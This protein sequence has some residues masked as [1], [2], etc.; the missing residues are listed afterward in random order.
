MNRTFLT[1]ITALIFLIFISVSSFAGPAYTT[2]QAKILKP[3]G[4]PL[5]ANPVQF[6]FTILNSNADCILYAETFSNINMNSSNGLISF[7][8]GSG[9]KNYPASATTFE[10]VFSN[11]TPTLSCNGVSP[12]TYSPASADARKVVMQFHDGSGWQTLPAMSINAVPY[13]MYANEAQKISGMPT[14]T[15]GEA[16]FY[17]GTTFS[18]VAASG[19]G[20]V[21]SG[22]VITALG[23]TPADGVSVTTLSSSITSANANI[24]SVSSTVFSVSS[25]VTSLVSTVAASFAAITSSQW[26]TS[27]SAVYYNS[28]NVGIGS[29]TPGAKL[30]V[31]GQVSLGESNSI[32]SD[33][34]SNKA[35]I[36]GNNNTYTS[37]GGGSNEAYSFG[38]YNTIDNQGSGSNS[39]FLFGSRNV[40]N[41]S[42]VILGYG[43][44]NTAIDSVAIGYNATTL[45]VL[46]TGFV[47]IGTTAPATS[48]DVSG[49]IKIGIESNTCS[50]TLAG[51]LRYNSTVVEYCNGTS[52]VAF[53]VSGA[54]IMGLNGLASGTQTFA[55]GTNGTAPNVSSTGTVHTFNFP[56]A[57]VGTTTAGV[58]SNSDYTTFMNK[59]TSSAV[60]IAQVLGYVPADAVSLTTLASTINIVSSALTTAQSDIASVSS[61]VASVSSSVS[62]LAATVNAVSA[63]ANSAQANAAAV[64]STVAAVSASVSSL[65]NTVAASFAAVASSQWITSGTTVNYNTGNVGIGTTNPGSKLTVSGTSNFTGQMILGNTPTA[66]SSFNF[67]P[68]LGTSTYSSPFFVQETVTDLTSNYTFGKASVLKL[69]SSANSSNYTMN[70]MNYTHVVPGNFMNYGQVYGGYNITE[71]NGS[72]NIGELAGMGIMVFQNGP[73]TAT[74]NIGINS[75]VDTYNGAST[76]SIAGWFGSQNSAGSVTNNYGVKIEPAL[77]TFGVNYGLHIGD[78]STATASSTY[79]IYSDG[80]SAMNIFMGAVGVGTATPNARLQIAAGGALFAPLKLTS[81]TLITSPQSGSVEY[82]GAN[83]YYTD[84]TN[85]RRSIATASSVSAALATVNASQWTTSGTTINY[86]TGN[87]G[88][89]TSNPTSTLNI[90]NS[91]DQSMIVLKAV[92]AQSAPWVNFTDSANVSKF[93]IAP[94]G[95]MPQ[96]TLGTS[97]VIRLTGEYGGFAEVPA[98][99]ILSSNGNLS[100]INSG[101]PSQKTTIGYF[102]GTNLLS[103]LELGNVAAGYGNLLL[104]RSGGYVGVGTSNPTQTL[105]VSGTAQA[106]KYYAGD[107]AFNSPSIAFA[108]NTNTG[109]YNSGGYI[110]ISIAGAL[111]GSWSSSSLSFNAGGAG[112][113]INFTGGNAA[114]PSYAF[115]VDSDTG[116]FNPN[117]SGGSNELG[118]STSGIER[119]RIASSGAVGIGTSAPTSLLHLAAGSASMA[120]LKLTSG[121]LLASPA[122]GAIEYDGTSLYY[123]DGTNTR[124][125][126]AA[127]AGV[128]TYDSASLISNSSGNITMYP[129][130][131]A[132][133]VVISATTASTSSGTG[134]LVVKGGLGVQGSVN[135]AGNNY[136]SGSET[137]D[138][139]FKLTT[140]TSGS[141]LFAQSN[142]QVSQDNNNFFWDNSAKRLGIGTSAPTYALQVAPSIDQVAWFSRTGAT[143]NPTVALSNGSGILTQ[144]VAGGASSYL[145]GTAQGDAG[146]MIT[147]G[148][149]FHIGTQN[150]SPTLTVAASGNVGV[151]TVTPTGKLEIIPTTQAG[152][153]VS[154]NT[155]AYVG[156][157]IIIRRTGTSTNVGQGSTLQFDDQSDNTNSNII[158]QA[159]GTL[160]F[161]NNGSGSWTE[162]M[163]IAKSGYVGIGVSSPSSLLEISSSG[164]STNVLTPAATT[165][166]L[167]NTDSTSGNTVDIRFTGAGGYPG[168]K[169]SGIFTNQTSTPAGAL[170]FMTTNNSVTGFAERMRI[171]PNGN[172]GI[173]TSAPTVALEVSGAI[174][175]PGVGQIGP[176]GTYGYGMYV[177]GTNNFVGQMYGAAS[178]VQ[179]TNSIGAN[180]M[181]IQD[182]GDVGIGGIAA[183]SRLTVT[184]NAVNANLVTLYNSAPNGVSGFNTYS[185]SGSLTGGFGWGNWNA[186]ALYNDKMFISSN[187]AISL[188]TNSVERLNITSGGL[189]GIG[190]VPTTALGVLNSTPTLLIS[191]AEQNPGDGSSEGKLAFGSAGVEWA[192]IGMARI[193]GQADDVNEMVFKTSWAAGAGGPGTNVER[194]RINYQG[195]VGIATNVP[196]ATLDVSG[197]FRVTGQAYTNTGT[198]TFNVLSDI[199]YKD[200]HGSYDRGLSEILNIDV[201]KFNYKKNNPLGSDPT[202]E[203]VGVSAQ[204]VQQNIPEAVEVR[205]DGD[206]EYLTLN[207]TPMFWT[208]INAVKEL[209]AKVVGHDVELA[210][211]TRRIANLEEQNAAKDKEIK[212][213][214]AYLCAKDPAAP[215]CK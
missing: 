140:M 84:G 108:N 141:I 53:G 157:D 7:S 193:G 125:T 60:S 61:T 207:I 8:L 130:G 45:N 77:G 199:R 43:V 18:C 215:I 37:G 47:G 76:N 40:A 97:N 201:I 19:G 147:S 137:I 59:I 155:S 55:T 213:L 68:L 64:S 153:V 44:S 168:A 142:G 181:N 136:V 209:Y 151:G 90:V 202:H 28:G 98:G 123:T 179:F 13:A 93:V 25:T 69:D 160:Q 110:G 117:S 127:T 3:D 32:D 194:M 35:S 187:R 95:G 107:G 196:Q 203:Y 104:M 170:S 16:L 165:L 167:T 38:S 182:N 83:L 58:I 124:R 116:M 6:K 66:S 126:L 192:S 70:A 180:T 114:T 154:G 113:Q 132:G 176:I 200:V 158:Q 131:G 103:G 166:R 73:G 163:R 99:S 9:V 177:T 1:S 184:A 89:G 175:I 162:R 190:L 133:S 86:L 186:A 134:A 204:N 31:N 208:M 178:G 65:A 205:K 67:G 145:A 39:S 111:K 139:T 33:N 36:F 50:S 189:V 152:V 161:F 174:R 34:S 183:I 109:F 148:K 88:V 52:W 94:N 138:G 46:S 173:G 128:G 214:K 115:N 102:N 185:S 29:A 129:N 42:V 48:L 171:D 17:N 23:Y 135:I 11:I 146:I 51:T 119:V 191:D 27:G 91:S 72:G 15:A 63:T 74:Y 212:D 120:P 82:D 96:L 12:A 100:L 79:N 49:G 54:G 87:I 143:D 5:E 150:T 197:T 71:A 92:A 195:Y 75:R 198:A 20:A 4:Q 2:Y 56:F 21:T 159:S 80:P 210:K 122:S 57:S 78:Q 81:G 206:K 106:T 30:T 164:T 149:K 211:Q 105:D 172:I 121:T 41:H 118:F 62:A 112:P 144:F 24:T 22:S 169:I 14:C 156:A 85:T 188:I 101:L 10:Q 26:A